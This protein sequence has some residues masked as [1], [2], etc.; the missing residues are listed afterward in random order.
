MEKAFIETHEFTARVS[1][2]LSD[3]DYTVLQNLLK[4]HP[5]LGKVMPGCGGMRKLR[6]TDPRRGKG[7]R[8]GI[9][10][11]YVH[12]P[13]SNRIYMVDLYDKGERDDLTAK[14]KKLF[15]KLVD[16]IKRDEA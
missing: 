7:K 14:E 15:A 9:R 6:V 5:D 12:I 3:D 11:L 1:A 16:T 8:G 13:E 4:A 10:I 2:F